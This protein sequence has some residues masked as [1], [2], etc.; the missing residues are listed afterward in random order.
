MFA[1]VTAVA[2]LAVAVGGVSAG[3]S[4]SEAPETDDTTNGEEIEPEESEDV[5]DETTDS[6]EVSH[7]DEAE[8]G[9]CVVGADSPCN[10]ESADGE[11]IGNDSDD[12]KQIM[13]PE[14]QNRDGEIDDRF[15]N[16]ENADVGVCIIGADSACNSDD[17]EDGKVGAGGADEEQ[18]MVPEDQ[19]R[20]GEIDD[21]FIGEFSFPAQLSALLTLF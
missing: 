10:G 4:S 21:R 11:R 15:T 9:I 20:D 13:I 12:G 14:D 6:G 8:A 19:N 5:D 3:V 17:K 2:V 16:D 18:I 1:L 7:A